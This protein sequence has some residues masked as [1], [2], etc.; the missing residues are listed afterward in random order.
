MTDPEIVLRKLT[1]LREHARRLQRRRPESVE[2]FRD[3]LD[4]Q[5][6]TAMSL[7][8]AVQDAL[9]IA[10]HV[11]AEEG[12]GIPGSYAESFEILARQGFLDPEVARQ[13]VGMATLRNRIAHGYASV[14]HARIWTELPAGIAALERFAG[15][16]AAHLGPTGG[17]PTS[18]SGR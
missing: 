6:A 10:L 18:G 13:L 2:T 15:A 3:D 14:D 5:D 9:D 7:L 4:L 12:W 17:E 11:A 1:S 16:V 8:V